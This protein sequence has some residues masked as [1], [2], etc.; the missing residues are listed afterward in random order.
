MQSISTNHPL[1]LLKELEQACK[2]QI[3][4]PPT[5]TNQT[6]VW[7]GFGFRI[8]NYKLCI[9]SKV[10]DELLD[11]H[12]QENLSKVPGAKTWLLG[13]ISLRGQALPLIDL[14]QYLFNTKSELS[15]KSRLLVINFSTSRTGLI[16]DE[17]Y[18]LKQFNPEMA[19]EPE[20]VESI[21]AEL[22]KFSSQVFMQNQQPWIEFS[23]QLL[24]ND[25]DFLNAARF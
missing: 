25:P 22:R 24:E 17:G 20:S 15:K 9:D 10:I 19:K 16:V 13:L 8:G 3:E 7:S 2:Q 14:N 21:P 5:S 12:F 23:T 6:K 4:T 1:Q 11:S 18:G